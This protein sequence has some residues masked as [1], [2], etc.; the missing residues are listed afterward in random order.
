MPNWQPFARG[1]PKY[2]NN[3]NNGWK[4]FIKLFCSLP[5]QFMIASHYAI[6]SISNKVGLNIFAGVDVYQSS[7]LNKAKSAKKLE[8]FE[9]G[10]FHTEPSPLNPILACSDI[11]PIT[12]SG[13]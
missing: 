12:F 10:Q 8:V 13:L 3:K 9:S 5:F 11:N 4:R 6:F 1:R 2:K 7:G